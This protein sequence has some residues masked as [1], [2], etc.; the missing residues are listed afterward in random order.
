MPNREFSKVILGASWPHTDPH[1]W[2]QASEGQHDKGAQLIHHAGAISDIA[3]QALQ[4]QS[5]NFVE[6]Y[7]D[8]LQRHARILTNQADCYFA[9][10]RGCDEVSRLIYGEREDLDKIDRDAHEKIEEIRAAAKGSVNQSSAT[11][12]IMQEVTAAMG[13]A[14]GVDAKAGASIA[15]QAAKMAL[16]P[17]DNSANGAPTEGSDD[18]A[19]DINLD[20]VGQF[21]GGGRPGPGG[22]PQG[23]GNSGQIPD[24]PDHFGDKHSGDGSDGSNTPG[25]RDPAQNTTTQGDPT[26]QGPGFDPTKHP[27][28]NGD[29]RG[30]DPSGLPPLSMPLGGGGSSSGGGGGGASPLSSAGGG[31]SSLK[32]PDMSSL[33]GMGGG[34]GGMGSGGMPQG[35]SSGSG[36]TPSPAIPPAASSSFAQ[37]MNAGLSGAPAAPL[38]PP[39]TSAPPAASAAPAGGPS[40]GPP[41]VSA[42]AGPPV[43]SP[44]AS[45]MSAPMASGPVPGGGPM[46]PLPPFGSD[47]RSAATASGGAA[48]TPASGSASPPSVA[49]DRGGSGGGG[50][51]AVPPGV[52]GQASGVGAGVGAEGARASQ[53]D[54]LLESA[55]R[56][57][58]KLL[59]DSR[60][61]PLSDWCV[62]V[63]RTAGGVETFIVNSDGA[64]FIPMDVFVPRSTRMVFS[65]PG[66]PAE[67]RARWFSW[68]NPAE[69]MVAFAQWAG[70][71]VELYAL[72]VSTELGG[73]CVPARDAGVPHVAESCRKMLPPN[74]RES[75]S[76]LDDGHKHRLETV[77]RGLYAR[78]VGVGEGRRPDQSEAWRTTAEAAQLALSRAG[79]LPDLAVPP[80]IREVLDSVK[81]GIKVSPQLWNDL[82]VAHS[83]AVTTGAGLRPG[84]LGTDEVASPHVLAHFDL[85][86]LMEILQLWRSDSGDRRDL[87]Y[88]DIA[89]LAKQ[90]SDTPCGVTP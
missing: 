84:L 17:P 83:V 32:P 67:F 65:D 5:G 68:A 12:A 51:L 10:A 18:S 69:T 47:V 62:G 78:L 29:H 80:V 33:P 30:L 38:A 79:A 71:H 26:D 41:A 66:L 23:G 86:R 61:A 74:S 25:E 85:A 19:P 27:G 56:L 45:P 4:N 11:A 89:Y 49:G 22:M 70:D 82:Q 87:Q 53:P 13:R 88:A 64:G 8:M 35:L 21:G 1:S 36:M 43:S 9:M 73:S 24:R 76:R 72:A 7:H 55:I 77:D 58:D 50:S 34:L 46:G 3:K 57:L 37:G 60:S 42:A 75:R 52:L 6:Q 59:E 28:K 15:A 63:F 16:D 44:A 81:R 39:V 20:N 40:A 14:K 31:L 54:P 90:I 48:V 2:H